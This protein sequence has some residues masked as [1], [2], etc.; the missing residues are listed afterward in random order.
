LTRLA[1]CQHDDP[2]ARSGD[3]EMVAVDPAYQR[4]G[5]AD[6]LIRFAVEQMR[7]AGAEVAGVVTGGD[8]GHAPARRAYE[9]AGFTALPLVRYYRAL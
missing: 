9:K 4:Q 7:A 2:E 3:I 8:P 5:I 1:A 6:T